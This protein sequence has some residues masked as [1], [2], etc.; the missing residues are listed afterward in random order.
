MTSGLVEGSRRKET[1]WAEGT[2]GLE[3]HALANILK[4]FKIEAN[5]FLVLSSPVGTS[6]LTPISLSYQPLLWQFSV[7]SLIFLDSPPFAHIG[8][9][10]PTRGQEHEWVIALAVLSL[11]VEDIQT[12]H[13]GVPIYIRGDANVNPNHPTRPQLLQEFLDCFTL[14]KMD[15]G[16]TTYHHFNGGGTSNSQLDVLISTL[17]NPETLED[18]LYARRIT[19]QSCLPMT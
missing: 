5:I 3:V 4:T 19:C 16:H 13:S 14:H 18:I 6:A 2:S 8:V 9:Y 17:G 11:I 1:H 10:L 12:A 7:F 15:L